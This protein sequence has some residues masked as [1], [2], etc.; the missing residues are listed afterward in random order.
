MGQ[1]DKETFEL[2]TGKALHMDPDPVAYVPWRDSVVPDALTPSGPREIAAIG[3]MLAPLLHFCRCMA[4]PSSK[5]SSSFFRL[6]FGKVAVWV[7]VPAVA[8]SRECLTGR[9]NRY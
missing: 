2:R 4:V 3:V 9:G 8:E 1:P 5:S 6:A 7:L